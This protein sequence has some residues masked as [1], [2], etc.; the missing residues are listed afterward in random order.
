LS[1]QL[2]TSPLRL[3]VADG[4]AARARAERVV[5]QLARAGIATDVV[6]CAPA[7][8]DP[9][10]GRLAL[11]WVTDGAADAAVH[12]GDELPIA[13]SDELVLAAV[14]ERLDPRDA[15]VS[16]QG[17][18]L[19]TLPHTRP[20]GVA[21]SGAVRR[22]Q[23]Q[24]QRR[25]LLLQEGP[26]PLAARLQAVEAAD[27]DAAVVGVAEL[28]LARPPSTSLVVV[29]L[30]HGEVLHRPGQGATAVTCLRRS[31]AVRK[32]LARLDDPLARVELDAERELWRQLSQDD[33]PLVA[34]HAEV[35][36]SVSGQ[37]RLVLLGLL[38]DATGSR[39]ARASHE[40][41]PDDAVTLG[42][43]MAATLLEA[44]TPVT[45]RGHG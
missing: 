30:E 29:P 5:A 11:Q 21:A 31:A 43:A 13:L 18:G 20:V 4:A 28:L 6:P 23:L 2:G 35:R 24:R 38:S 37:Q 39:S 27:V 26:G 7:D 36:R 14:P 12:A 15:L 34:A 33:D 42:R 19:A 41:A 16:R 8:G 22:A 9:T 25:D 40:T 44:T 45:S 10:G 3:A 1:E 17:W 32:L